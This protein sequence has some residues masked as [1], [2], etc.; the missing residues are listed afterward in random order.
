MLTTGPPQ[1]MI[2]FK[3]KDLV[4]PNGN[5]LTVF[6]PRR[7]VDFRDSIP[8]PSTPE[9]SALTARPRQSLK[10]ICL[11]EVVYLKLKIEGVPEQLF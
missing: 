9:A 6:S 3:L 10:T 5:F 4:I 11:K 2:I 7:K 1:Q 8:Q